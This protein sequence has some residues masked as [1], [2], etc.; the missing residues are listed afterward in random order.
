[1]LDWI[2]TKNGYLSIGDRKRLIETR[3]FFKNNDFVLIDRDGVINLVPKN[4]RYLKS[5]SNLRI[6][7]KLINQLPIDP[8][9]ICITN[10][11][12]ISTGE[13]KNQN[14]KII[15]KKIIKILKLRK[16]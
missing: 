11:A 1:M 13:V 14:L 7:L 6:N 2:E 15:N 8:K 3:C 12:G 10:Q 9:Y 5:I 4:E 16:N